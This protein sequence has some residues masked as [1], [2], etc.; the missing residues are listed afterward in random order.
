MRKAPIHAV[1]TASQGRGL[2]EF[3]SVIQTLFARTL[4]Y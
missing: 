4:A 2:K 1:T 3:C